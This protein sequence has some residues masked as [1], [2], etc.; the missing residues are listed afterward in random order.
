[1]AQRARIPNKVADERKKYELKGN[2][3][4]CERMCV[5]VLSMVSEGWAGGFVLK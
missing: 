1:M 5:W 4:E 2:A 3:P